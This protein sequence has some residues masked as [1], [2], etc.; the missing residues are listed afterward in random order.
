MIH[1]YEKQDKL[2]QTGATPI[3][4]LLNLGGLFTLAGI[5]ALFKRKK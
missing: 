3:S 2:P 4:T 1:V 5:S